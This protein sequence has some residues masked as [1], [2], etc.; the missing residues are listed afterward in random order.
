MNLSVRETRAT[1]TPIFRPNLRSERIIALFRHSPRISSG[2]GL[3]KGASG[4]EEQTDER[5]ATMSGG[6]LLGASSC[7]RPTSRS[8]GNRTFR[9]AG[10][11]G[12]GSVLQRAL[13]RPVVPLQEQSGVGSI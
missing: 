8:L 6:R 4:R 10:R 13:G 3:L 12:H 7:F 1:R 5:Y 2:S 11:T 9:A